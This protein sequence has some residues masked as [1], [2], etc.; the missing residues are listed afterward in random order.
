MNDETELNK[1][2]LALQLKDNQYDALLQ[3]Y[4]DDACD[5]LRLRLS[6]K[7]IPPE[8][9]A[10]AR[11]AAVKK[12]NRLHNEGMNSYSQDGE[13]ISFDASDFNEWQ[14]ELDQF[15]ADQQKSNQGV[16]ADP[17]AGGVY[18]AL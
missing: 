14:A 3:L 13:S 16:F 1:L 6:I 9:Q 2:K 5:F 11:G 7:T 17:Y 15:K 4:L 8:L 10:I 18:H 12:F